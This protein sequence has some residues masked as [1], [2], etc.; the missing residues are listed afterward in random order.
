MKEIGELLEADRETRAGGALLCLAPTS[1]LAS[2]M[3]R[4]R[5]LWVLLPTVM[6]AHYKRRV[7]FSGSEHHFLTFPW[8]PSSKTHHPEEKGLRDCLTTVWYRGRGHTMEGFGHSGSSCLPRLE[9]GKGDCHFFCLAQLSPLCWNLPKISSTAASSCHWGVM[10]LGPLS[11]YR[12]SD[13]CS[14][15]YQ[16]P[17]EPRTGSS[18]APSSAVRRHQR[19]EGDG[20]WLL[21]CR[22]S[23]REEA[24]E[25]TAQWCPPALWNVSS[26][27]AQ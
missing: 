18:W 11:I 1:A 7:C 21:G 20:E 2:E 4:R 8:V 15:N 19:R 5:G 3:D 13:S 10:M 26:V 23:D 6:G 27:R 9:P 14:D 25:R 12:D 16:I 17:W 22:E 24:E